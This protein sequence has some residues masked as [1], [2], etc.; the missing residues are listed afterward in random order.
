MPEQRVYTQISVD[1]MAEKLGEPMTRWGLSVVGALP[2]A[3]AD[4]NVKRFLSELETLLEHMEKDPSH[5]FQIA[6]YRF[7][8]Y[9]ISY[10]AR[11]EVCKELGAESSFWEFD[12]EEGRAAFARLHAHRYLDFTERTD[13]T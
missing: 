3:G 13:G 9:H 8:L 1:E 5:R 10:L 4:D 2:T 11:C 6:L 7:G 12:T